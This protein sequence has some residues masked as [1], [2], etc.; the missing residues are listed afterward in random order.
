[1]PLTTYSYVVEPLDVNWPVIVSPASGSFSTITGSVDIETELNFCASSGS[2]SGVTVLPYTLESCSSENLP[3]ADVRIALNLPY[4]NMKLYGNNEHFECLQCLAKPEVLI[5]PAINLDNV[6]LNVIDF[7][8]AISGLNYNSTYNYVIE[9]LDSNSLLGF[10]ELSGTIVTNTNTVEVINSKMI[11]CENSGECSNYST[12]GA[13]S[14]CLNS[15][16]YGNIRVKITSD[17]LDYPVYSDKINIIC[18]YCWPRIIFDITENDSIADSNEYAFSFTVNSLQP[19]QTYTYSITNIESNNI[20]AFESLSGLFTTDEDTNFTSSSK[21]I[22]CDASG[23]YNDYHI[24]NNSENCDLINKYVKFNLTLD[25]L[26]LDNP[27]SSKNTK[28]ECENCLPDRHSVVLQGNSLYHADEAIDLTATIN[29]T[30]PNHTYTYEFDSIDGNWPIKIY[31][32]SGSFVADDDSRV[33]L[34]QASFCCPSGTCSGT[35]FPKTYDS[36]KYKNNYLTQDIRLNVTDTCA[37]HIK[38]DD[39]TIFIQLKDI[40][41][42]PLDD[43]YN[44]VLDQTTN[45]CYN[46]NMNIKECIN[47]H[48]Y[49]YQYNAID[50]NW[51]VILSNVSGTFT[52]RFPNNLITTQLSFCPSTG[53]CNNLPGSISPT[54]VLNYGSILANNCSTNN[55]FIKLQLSVYSNCYANQKLFFSQPI[56]V[57]CEDCISAPS[58]TSAIVK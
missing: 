15:L 37:N 47:T 50:G 13:V 8:I 42:E 36:F 46:L 21:I 4:S 16:P 29:N 32:I 19:Y 18:D 38:S 58:I 56:T 53:I 6:T 5:P 51:P 49:T 26:C 44:V 1:M 31:P 57:Y 45:G 30:I 48:T 20:I 3:F 52:N 54:N 10:S 43:V 14:N 9:L 55:K 22:F 2:C 35:L 7:P 24:V 17:C 25:S 41:V 11:L 23:Y 34:A 12:L 33:I 27:V 40:V 28:I 39:A